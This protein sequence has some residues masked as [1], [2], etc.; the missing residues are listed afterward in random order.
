MQFVCYFIQNANLVS[1][2]K[3][4]SIGKLF[5]I[6]QFSQDSISSFFGVFDGNGR[7]ALLGPGK[8]WEM[9]VWN[10]QND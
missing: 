7:E 6:K 3:S 5:W 8:Q 4:F 9:W 10:L 1:P 2:L